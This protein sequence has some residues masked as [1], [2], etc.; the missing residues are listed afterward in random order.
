M[1]PEEGIEPSTCSL[2][3]SRSTTELPGHGRAKGTSRLCCYLPAISANRRHQVVELGDDVASSRVGFDESG[4]GGDSRA[5]TRSASPATRTNT[6]MV[7]NIERRN[8]ADLL[9]LGR[10]VIDGDGV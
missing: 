3:E 8:S 4:C 2:R 9:S 1:E 7:V 10:V 5:Q 6:E